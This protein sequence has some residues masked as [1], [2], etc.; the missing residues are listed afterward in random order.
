MDKEI[1]FPIMDITEFLFEGE[2]V[3]F[4][5]LTWKS[6]YTLKEKYVRK[7]P[8]WQFVDSEGKL[9]KVRITKKKEIK[10]FFSFLMQPTYELE[11]QLY[12]TG[13]IYELDELKNEILKKKH[14][15]FHIY[16]NKL[17]TLDEYEKSLKNATTFLR[18]IDIASFEDYKEN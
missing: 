2:Q 17:M 7:I 6:Q 12:P 18:I 10:S 3:F 4:S 14:K 8:K 15:M 9:L 13:K 1:K 11:L 5:Y 16:E